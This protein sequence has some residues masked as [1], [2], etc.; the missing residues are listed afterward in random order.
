MFPLMKNIH[1]SQLK[2]NSFCLISLI[3]E[4]LEIDENNVLQTHAGLKELLGDLE[5]IREAL[6]F[7]TEKLNMKLRTIEDGLKLD[8]MDELS[9]EIGKMDLKSLGAAKDVLEKNRE[10]NHLKRIEKAVKYLIEVEKGNF[11]VLDSLISSEEK[12]DWRFVCFFLHN[13]MNSLE[14][15]EELLKYSKMIESK[16]LH[17]FEEG[18]KQGNRTMMKSA[19]NALLEMNKE[20][21][22]VH[23]YIYSLDL[24]KNPVAMVH[25]K[26]DIVDFDFYTNE[27]NTFVRLI[28]QIRDT[29]ESDFSDLGSIFPNPAEV[30]K[31]VHKKVYEDLLYTALKEYL[32]DTTPCLFLLSLGS[33]HRNIKILGSSIESIDPDFDSCSAAED[34]LSQYARMAVDKEKVLFDEIYGI[35]VHKTRG[36]ATYILLGSEA[37]FTT[38]YVFL[39]KQLL[40][41]IGFALERSS[42]FYS[43]SDED[44]LIEFFFRKINGLISMV[45]D[46]VQD[47][48]ELVKIL[49]FMYL[50]T[51][52]YFQNKF[53]KLDFFAK[54]IE[55]KIQDAFADEIETCRLRIEVRTKQE[56]FVDAK[57]CERML[58]VVRYEMERAVEMSVKGKHFKILVDK[59]FVFVYTALNNQILQIVFDEEQ[60]ANLKKYVND[61]CEFTKS[62]GSVEIVQRFLYLRDLVMLI[63]V[64]AEEFGSFYSTMVGKIPHAEASRIVKC[65]RDREAVQ[66]MIGP[67]RGLS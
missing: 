45:F 49:R 18:Q 57:G 34:L 35:L 43:E 54:K 47:R 19:Y 17:A 39:Y 2:A 63:T 27:S 16:M 22:L 26:K 65:R 44:E 32:K 50:V 56:Y 52:K 30:Y 38:D 60:S 41:L 29:Y 14:S 9:R 7:K 61:L 20:G 23:A 55:K 8:K 10:I 15:S 62:L 64:P 66:G 40:N 25:E 4:T 42:R 37:A 3:E 31:V 36:S 13:V 33:C 24:F 58:D 48:F 1:V 67:E 11:L 28:G 53:W 5:S 59:I 6:F 46:S 21:S 12:E 51:R